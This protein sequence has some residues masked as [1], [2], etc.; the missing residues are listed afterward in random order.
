MRVGFI[1]A[2]NMARALA[3]GLG[4]PVLCTDSGSGRARQL[5]EELGG[6]ALATNR[7][8]A[9]KADV[10]ILAHKP[11]QLDAVASEVAGTARA[12]VSLLARTPQSEVARAYPDTPV[13]RAEPNLPVEVGRG[14]TAI[15]E[16]EVDVDEALWAEVN[17]LFGKV[18]SVVV[19]PERLM[20]VAG[21]CAGV[22]PAYWALLIE[23]QVDAAVR[24]G[25]P[26]AQA[27]ELVAGTMRGTAE[28][29]HA[30]GGDT[31]QLRREVTSPGGTTSRGLAALERGGVRAAFH[32]ALDAVVDG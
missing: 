15:A 14:V 7:E 23:A 18:G 21:G 8:L 13:I 16:P 30:R 26:A 9:E 29:L 27:T 17:A 22:G 11:V 24:R 2:G 4:E 19:L 10:V 12:V 31:L 6:E 28:L 1:G 25:L 5:A 20:T 3:R 32:A